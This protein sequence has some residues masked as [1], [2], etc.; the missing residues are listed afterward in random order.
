MNT[1]NVTIGKPK[2]TGAISCAPLG[3]ALPTDATTAL[4][5][6]FKVLG[7][8][9]DDGVTNDGSISTEKTKAWGGDVVLDSQTE[10][11]DYFKMKLIEA[12]NVEVLKVVHNDANV[13]GTLETGITVKANRE[14]PV[15]RVWVIDMVLKNGGVKRIVIPK[16]KITTRD[17]IVYS[18]KSPIGYGITIAAAP[19]TS[20]NTHYEYIKG[21]SA[22]TTE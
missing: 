20:G 7:Y 2:T 11:N 5:T 18:D 19:D 22:G 12:T 14:E 4:D 15:E 9:S 3:T 6:A 13:S 1:A 8:A 16:G 10:K 17:E 21:A